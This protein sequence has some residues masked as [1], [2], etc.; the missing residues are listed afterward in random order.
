MALVPAD[1]TNDLKTS[2]S[3]F[4]D[5][6]TESSD[7]IAAAYFGYCGNGAF[8]TSIP[9]LTPALE[10]AMAATLSS[11]MDGTL[12]GFCNGIQ[13]SVVTFWTAVVVAGGSGAG[14]S[15]PPT[16]NI[17]ATLQASLAVFPPTSDAAAAIIATQMDI[18]TKTTVA[19]LTIP[20]AS[21]VIFP[22][23]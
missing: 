20:P 10:S 23:L 5:D 21:P 6:I 22:L 13:D 2:F 12:S 18:L 15:T 1:L 16:G 3:S 19:S 9:T 17:V 8:G 11:S 4:P 7:D 14:A